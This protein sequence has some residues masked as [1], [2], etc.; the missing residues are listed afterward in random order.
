MFGQFLII[1]RPIFDRLWIYKLEL[2]VLIVSFKH[3][4]AHRYVLTKMLFGQFLAISGPILQGLYIYILSSN[5]QK[6]S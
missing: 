5:A 6:L 3:E 4:A 2:V 1:I